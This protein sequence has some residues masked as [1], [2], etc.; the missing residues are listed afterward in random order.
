MVRLNVMYSRNQYIRVILVANDYELRR[1][2]TIVIMPLS[3]PTRSNWFTTTYRSRPLSALLCANSHSWFQGARADT[4]AAGQESEAAPRK[5]HSPMCMT[6]SSTFK[7]P[8]PWTAAVALRAQCIT[9]CRASTAMWCSPWHSHTLWAFL[10]L[11]TK[12]KT[13]PRPPTSRSR[14]CL[15]S[16]AL[17]RLVQR[18]AGTGWK[19]DGTH[20]CPHENFQNDSGQKTETGTFII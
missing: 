9:S 6:K 10:V 4:E 5:C 7:N 11:V 12:S 2:N 19:H 3:E 20:C 13:L 1:N 17:V 15:S 18:G 14:V 8:Q 16:Q